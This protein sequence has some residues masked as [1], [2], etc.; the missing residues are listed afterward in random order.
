MILAPAVRCDFAT[1]LASFHLASV[2]HGWVHALTV[3]LV[4]FSRNADVRLVGTGTCHSLYEGRCGDRIRGM[5]IKRVC[6]SCNAVLKSNYDTC[7]YR[8]RV[9]KSA[10]III[11]G[12]PNPPPAVAH[13]QP[14]PVRVS[15]PRL[16]V[17]QGLDENGIERLVLAIGKLLLCVVA[18]AITIAL[19]GGVVYLVV[20]FVHWAW[21]Q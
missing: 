2:Y 12:S 8:H 7:W 4:D 18:A 19:M 20:R 5:A 17:Y 15:S 9:L 11:V 1:F 13:A 6:R 3:T 14:Q 21:N 10:D 16:T